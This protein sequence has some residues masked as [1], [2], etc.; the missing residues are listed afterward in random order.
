[1]RIPE[2]LIFTVRGSQPWWQRTL[3]SPVSIGR[4]HEYFSSAEEK[5]TFLNYLFISLCGEKMLLT[6]WN[7]S[8]GQLGRFLFKST[9]R[10]VSLQGSRFSASLHTGQRKK[11]VGIEDKEK[12]KRAKW[13]VLRGLKGVGGDKSETLYWETSETYHVCGAHGDP[14]KDMSDRNLEMWTYLEK[15]IFEH[16]IKNLRWDHTGLEWT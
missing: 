13:A 9:G 2:I 12:E 6:E 3:E 4:G 15:S 5:I 8:L 14:P 10:R 16:V 11:L 1:M 7:G